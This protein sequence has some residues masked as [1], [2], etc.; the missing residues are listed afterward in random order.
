MKRLL[1]LTSILIFIA[2][3]A[4]SE[5]EGVYGC[6]VITSCNFNADANIFDNSCWYETEGCFCD[7]GQ[8]AIIDGCGL[9]AADT[10]NDC[11]QDECGVWGGD[12]LLDIC[13]VCDNDPSNDCDCEESQLEMNAAL[14][15][16]MAGVSAGTATLVDCLA[17]VDK[18]QQY[19]DVGC[20]EEEGGLNLTQSSI[21][22]FIITFCDNLEEEE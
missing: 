3:Q 21:D 6:T 1:L 5:E 4:P 19:F 22:I 10:T 13:G 8:D 7:D 17:Y 11:V 14:E 18:M 12:G 16:Y 15:T 2:C 20:S 9:C